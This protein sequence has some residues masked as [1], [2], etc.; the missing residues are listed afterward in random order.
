MLMVFSD[1]IMVRVD[2]TVIKVKINAFLSRKNW[3]S[4]EIIDW[5]LSFCDYN[6]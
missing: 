6:G 5:Q 3:A 4:G 2:I 1:T